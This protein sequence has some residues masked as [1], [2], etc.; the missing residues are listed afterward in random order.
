[1]F[2]AKSE[3]IYE[4]LKHQINFNGELIDLD[5]GE[6]LKTFS[7]LPDLLSDFN[8]ERK[9]GIQPHFTSN[10]TQ[11]LLRYLKRPLSACNKGIVY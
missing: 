11:P 3:Y 2:K 5:L 6:E 1:M 8:K 4:Y 7:S 10:I 9:N